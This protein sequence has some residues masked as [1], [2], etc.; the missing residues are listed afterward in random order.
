MKTA[1]KVGPRRALEVA[2]ARS[3]KSVS[4]GWAFGGSE[5][6]MYRLLGPG[7]AGCRRR[8]SRRFCGGALG[9]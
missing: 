1:W 3:V 4:L 7:L 5:R 8:G 9:R 2:R 6:R